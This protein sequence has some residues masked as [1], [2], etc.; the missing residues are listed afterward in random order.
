MRHLHN[1]LKFFC[2]YIHVFYHAWPIH[3]LLFLNLSHQL[4]AVDHKPLSARYNEQHVFWK[5]W[6][7]I[8]HRKQFTC[9]D[10]NPQQL[11][12]NEGTINYTKHVNKGILSLVTALQYLWRG[13]AV[14]RRRKD[15]T[16]RAIRVVTLILLVISLDPQSKGPGIIH[17]NYVRD[18]IW[19]DIM[20]IFTS[21]IYCI[22]QHYDNTGCCQALVILWC[23]AR[24]IV[25]GKQCSSW[26]A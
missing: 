5:I 10:K 18:G 21:T 7:L 1:V 17:S 15:A 26:A 25:G 8:F 12:Q 9:L 3:C 2:I 22:W 23:Y 24:G 13:K 20:A 16:K 19:M 6:I 4:H 11:F 14:S